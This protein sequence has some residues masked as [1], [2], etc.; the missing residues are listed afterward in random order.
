VKATIR[1]ETSTGE[2]SQRETF[3]VG[4]VQK[5]YVSTALPKSGS[6]TIFTLLLELFSLYLPSLFL[7]VGFVG[8]VLAFLTMSRMHENAVASFHFKALAIADILASNN[9]IHAV[10][11]QNAPELVIPWGE[12]FCKEYVFNGYYFNGVA[13]WCVVTLT[14]DRV[15]AVCFP[16][17][18][19]TFCTLKKAKIMLVSNFTIHVPIY[20]TFF[21]TE[22]YPPISSEITHEICLLPQWLPPWLITTQDLLYQIVDSYIPMILVLLG[23]LAIVYSIRRRDTSC[24]GAS[25]Q[26][27][28]DAGITLMLITMSSAFIIFMI[29]Y[30]LDYLFWTIFTHGLAEQYPRVRN[31]T[32][33]IVY[34]VACSN[35]VFNFYMYLLSS[36]RFRKNLVKLFRPRRN[37]ACST[38][39]SRSSNYDHFH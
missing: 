6:N 21:W 30:P 1:I 32:F 11:M 36:S 22:F 13:V 5:Q 33:A 16:F 28:D 39:S 35:N 29:A 10:V 25:Q 8:N 38:L 37:R 24:L 20:F 26:G 23:N 17:L 3:P 9:L 18:A 7:V 31:L 15:I 19:S 14:L 4:W 2:M 27:K 12:V 34:L